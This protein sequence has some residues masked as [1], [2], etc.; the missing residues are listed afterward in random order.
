MLS[1]AQLF[2]GKFS[3]PKGP[4]VKGVKL[5]QVFTIF[6]LIQWLIVFE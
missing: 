1:Q 6:D 5:H 3:L 2:L 4:K